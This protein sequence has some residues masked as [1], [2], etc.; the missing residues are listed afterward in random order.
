MQPKG[1]TFA[2]KSYELPM[3]L[4]S[5]SA[6]SAFREMDKAA[7]QATPFLVVLDYELQ[8]AYFVAHPLSQSE[9][10][11]SIQGHGNATQIYSLQGKYTF[12]PYPEDIDRYSKRFEEIQRALYRGDSFLANLTIAT[13]LNM[14]LSLGQVYDHVTATYKLHIPGRLVCFSPEPFVHISSD[15]IISSCPMKGT[16]DALLP[17]AEQTLRSDPKE[18][19]EHYTIVDLIRNDLSRVSRQV[20]VKR[21]AYTERIETNHGPILQMSSE[22]NGKL[23]EELQLCPGSVLR[24]LLPAGSICGAPK[25]ATMTA[26]ARAEE[27]T[28]GFY[29][30]IFGYFD[31]QSFSSAVMI[32]YIEQQDK[33]LPEEEAARS[34]SPTN[35]AYLFRSGGGITIHSEPER[36]YAETQQKVYLPF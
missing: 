19:A 24:Q 26:I 8:H 32:R 28:R 6:D 29:S 17:N 20:E 16:I 34:S 35:P 18:L 5:I 22:I 7:S 1:I 2:L 9:I 25:D 15:G 12:E 33:T 23:P 11:F 4:Q 13:P 30:G 14:S 36:E 31:G 21:F 3:S 27:T 10:R